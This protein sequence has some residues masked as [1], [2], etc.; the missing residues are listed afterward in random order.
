MHSCP[1]R[2]ARVLDDALAVKPAKPE[3][4]QEVLDSLMRLAPT[5]VGP[6]YLVE[7]NSDA[8]RGRSL[9]RGSVLSEPSANNFDLEVGCAGTTTRCSVRHAHRNW[10]G[11]GI[12]PV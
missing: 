12:R 4:Q 7:R 9:S 10:D 2:R 11:P 3:V 1:G 5:P 8:N 6:V